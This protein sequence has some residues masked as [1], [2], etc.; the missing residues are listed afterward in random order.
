[1]LGAGS[2]PPRQYVESR[3]TGTIV[4]TRANRDAPDSALQHLLLWPASLSVLA[5][6]AITIVPLLLTWA[7]AAWAAAGGEPAIPP[8][9]EYV[10]VGL[11]VAYVA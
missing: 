9:N 3:K 2:P 5:Q 6:S 11:L 7:V 1:M 10:L 8:L 4:S